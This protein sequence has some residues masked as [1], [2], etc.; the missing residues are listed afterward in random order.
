MRSHAEIEEVLK[1]KLDLAKSR[2]E[3][4]KGEF[5][6]VSRDLPS[7][8]PHPD[9]TQRIQNARREQTAAHE[10]FKAALRQFDAFIL[11]GEIPDHLAGKRSD[12]A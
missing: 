8:L 4:A 6:R 10:A 3:Y 7:G 1:A 2:Y 5:T 11:K 12:G 9:G